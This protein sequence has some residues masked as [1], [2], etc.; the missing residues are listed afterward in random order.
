[1]SYLADLILFLHFLYIL[2]VVLPVLTIPIGWKRGWPWVRSRTIRTVHAGM[3]GFV[4]FEIL[5]GMKCPLTV[6]EN[7]FLEASSRPSYQG[8]F[9]AHWVSQIMY[10]HMPYWVFIAVYASV[11]SLIVLLWRKYPPQRKSQD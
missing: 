7:R 6:L 10:W 9:M 2:G 11:F 4:L 1:M 3:M 8:D 5:V